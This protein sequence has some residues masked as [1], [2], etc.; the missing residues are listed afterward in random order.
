KQGPGRHDDVPGPGNGFINVFDTSGHLL[1][2][3]VAHGNLNSPWGLA[4]VGT[5]LWVG[6]FG[7]GKINNYDPTTGAFIETIS[8]ADG[9]ALVLALPRGGVPVAAIVARRLRAPLDVFV[10]RKLGLPGH[11]ELA[12]GA[13]AAGGVRVVNNDV[14]DSLRIPQSVFDSVAVEEQQ[15]LERRERLYRGELPPPNI[16]GKTIILIDDGI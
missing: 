14:V 7:D 8:R 10:V 6:N 5:E 13:L 2:H 12:M 4:L 11:A 16:N 3:L 9:S 15:E 1:R